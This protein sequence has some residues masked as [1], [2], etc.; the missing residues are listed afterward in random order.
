MA[1]E[2]HYRGRMTNTCQSHSQL[3]FD[4]ISLSEAYCLSPNFHFL[5][6]YHQ[7]WK[8]STSLLQSTQFF[9]AQI[10]HLCESI[11]ELWFQFRST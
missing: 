10:F 6:R 8:I 11:F 9:P 1:F 7:L 3:S 5:Y 2:I 4:I